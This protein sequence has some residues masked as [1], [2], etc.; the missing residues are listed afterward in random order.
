ML[1][2]TGGSGALFLMPSL[3]DPLFTP[4]AP[5]D[6]SVYYI[7]LPDSIGAGGSSKPSDG[8]KGKFPHY[9]YNDMVRA[10]HQLVTK[11]LKVDHLRLVTGLSMGGMETWIWS[12]KYPKM[13]DAFLPLV[14]LPIRVSGRNLIWR[15]MIVHSIRSDPEWKNGNYTTQPT[16]W[17]S[18]FPVM[19]MMDDSIR[20][21]QKTIP[22]LPAAHAFLDSAVKSAESLDANNFLYQLE[23]SRDY[24]PRPNLGKIRGW[25][26]AVNFEDDEVNPDVLQ[27]LERE[28][29]K[30]RHGRFVVIPSTHHTTGHSSA[31]MGHFWAPY[32]RKLLNEAPRMK[33]M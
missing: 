30:V 17:T 27:I 28:I 12:E 23:A 19:A 2:G 9:R 33:G 3:A 5:L 4:G 32:V 13:V 1:H 7:I 22:N 14:C 16:G 20:H 6:P 18:T 21:L 29:K 26:L 10:C 15:E 11:K 24:D 8:L 31:V 25:V